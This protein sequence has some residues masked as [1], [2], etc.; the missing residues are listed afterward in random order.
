LPELT[1]LSR[2]AI[3]T[4]LDGMVRSGWA[5]VDEGVVN[6]A[7]VARAARD[8]W[9]VA[10]ATAESRWPSTSSLRAPLEAVVSSLELEHPYYPC[11][12]GAADWRISGGRGADWRAV[13]RDPDADT[14]SSLLVLAML[15]QALVGFAVA[16]EE[17]VSFPLLVG[18]HFDTDFADGGPTLADA[19][20]ALAIAG[21]GN[22][23]LERHGLVTVDR[24]KRVRLT[25]L[26]L[27][28]RVAYRPAVE[29]VETS[30]AAA[31]ALRDALEALD[32][33]GVGHADHPDVRYVGGHVGFAEA[34]ARR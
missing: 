9:G 4:T 25:S 10:V 6:L 30:W 1:R 14:V 27:Q 8:D 18:V 12:Y 26:G 29:A 15:S 24:S 33:H 23:S 7:D 19:P 5:S 31:P 22:S 17:Q 13:P 3:K 16:Y 20:V 2:R 21:N 32:V 28:V 34:S 11:G